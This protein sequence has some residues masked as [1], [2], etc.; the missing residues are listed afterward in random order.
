MGDVSPIWA[1]AEQ[2]AAVRRA[3]DLLSDS[4]LSY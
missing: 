2:Q 4:L 1:A 3:V